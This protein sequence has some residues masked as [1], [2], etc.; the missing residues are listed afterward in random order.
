MPPLWMSFQVLVWRG[1]RIVNDRVF[2]TRSA[3]ASKHAAAL[4]EPAWTVCRET[5]KV[6]ARN[7]VKVKIGNE[8]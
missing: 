2:Y 6:M 5:G 3:I 8:S 1:G 7:K 4:T